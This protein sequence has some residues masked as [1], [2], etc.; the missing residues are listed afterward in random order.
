MKISRFYQKTDIQVGDE[1]ELSPA[2]HRH[3]IQ[4]LRLKIGQTLIIFN[5]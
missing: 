5:G 4:V 3:A 1:L 2:N